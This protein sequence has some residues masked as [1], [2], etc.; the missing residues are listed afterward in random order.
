MEDKLFSIGHIS[1]F[2]KVSVKTL[3]YYDEVN[4]VK[5]I[6]VNPLTRYRYYSPEQTEIIFLIK[7][8]R[9]LGFSLGQ[10]K[11]ALRQKGLE[12]LINLFRDREK[13]LRYLNGGRS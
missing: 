4:L 3:R 8:L 6:Y 7:V 10:I 11:K 13:T 12:G 5:P 9:E 1:E 2:C